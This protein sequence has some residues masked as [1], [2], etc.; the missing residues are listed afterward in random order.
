MKKR[1]ASD[2]DFKQRFQIGEV[3]IVV[4]VLFI[5][6]LVAVIGYNIFTELNNDIQADPDLTNA[7]KAEV[8]S[9]HSR[10]PA[11]MDGAFITA[12]GLLYLLAIIAAFFSDSHPVFLIIV[13]II[14]VLLL[15]AAGL[16]SNAWEEL[17]TDSD[18]GGSFQTDFPMTN[19]VLSNFLLVIAIV[20]MS[21]GGVM[22]MKNRY[23][24]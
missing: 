14:I 9:L 2:S 5:M 6:G 16:I 24:S 22:Y 19:Y 1:R 15:L 3:V 11:T 18:I 20:G 12:F 10:Y 8:D 13:I 23:L 21:I 4:V 17:N 7:T